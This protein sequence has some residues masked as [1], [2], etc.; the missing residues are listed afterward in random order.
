MNQLVN[1]RKELFC[2][3][4]VG[5]IPTN[6]DTNTKKINELS[7]IE[8]KLFIINNRQISEIQNEFNLFFPYLKIEFFKLPHKIGVG[9]HKKLIFEKDKFISDCRTSKNEGFLLINDEV[10]VLDV[11]QQF[12]NEFGLSIQVFRKSGKVWLETSATD[13]WTLKAQNTEGAELSS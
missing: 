12:F 7:K 5:L 4:Y 10:K 8:F 11:E 9:S 3:N 6:M 1:N 13:H 2:K